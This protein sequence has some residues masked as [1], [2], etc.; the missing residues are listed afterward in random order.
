MATIDNLVREFLDQKIFAVV[1]VSDKRN[2]GANTNFKTF[3]RGGYRVY[4][5][6]PRLSTYDGVPCY[7]D[8][9]SL[10]EKPDVVFMATS[11]GV[12][13]QIIQQCLDLEIKR[14]WMHCMMGTKPGLSPGSSSVSPSAVDMCRKYGIAVIPGS[15]PA[16][17][18]KADV[19]HAIMCKLWRA[20][21]F[22]K[23]EEAAQ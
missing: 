14:V 8:I 2:T 12:S 7:P 10:P 15:C 4:P 5:V 18:L 13:E 3:K 1:G 16:Q 6:N 21:G 9:T 11:P 17:F 20:V 23:I 22:L 19:G